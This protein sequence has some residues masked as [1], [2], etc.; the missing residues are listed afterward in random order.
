MDQET[1]FYKRV[2]KL[3]PELLSLKG[4]SN[5]IGI[6]PSSWTDITRGAYPGPKNAIKIRRFLGLTEGEMYWAMTGD[7]DIAAL[8]SQGE[9]GPSAVVRKRQREAVQKVLLVGA[10]I[11]HSWGVHSLTFVS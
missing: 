5:A 2:T 11:V 1:T 10:G 3:R 9:G 7:G 4:A 6:S 8:T